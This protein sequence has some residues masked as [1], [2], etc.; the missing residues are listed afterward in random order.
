MSTKVA[1]PVAESQLAAHNKK[2][3]GLLPVKAHLMRALQAGAKSTIL[4]EF[5]ILI[6]FDRQLVEGIP[7]V[8]ILHSV[9]NLLRVK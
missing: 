9:K 6:G 5:L 2:Q 1:D 4:F 8:R 3:A 7:Y